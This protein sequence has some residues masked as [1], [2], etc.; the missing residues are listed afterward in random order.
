MSQTPLLYF[1]DRCLGWLCPVSAQE[2]AQV[3]V[4]DT[5]HNTMSSTLIPLPGIPHP[6][7]PGQ[8][9][10]LNHFSSG[11]VR[12]CLLFFPKQGHLNTFYLRLDNPPLSV[13]WYT[14]IV[15]NNGF[16]Y[17]AF[18]YVYMTLTILT[19]HCL[20]LPPHSRDLSFPK[21]FVL[22]VVN[23]AQKS[24]CH[25]FSLTCRIKIYFKEFH[26]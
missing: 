20:L 6:E 22:K 10:P 25:S 4:L 14:S 15:Q 21:S 1:P 9:L 16:P 19:L 18:T 2:R 3:Y 7:F 5:N 17:E 8:L 11:K 12:V 23:Q 26:S 24:N 13:Y